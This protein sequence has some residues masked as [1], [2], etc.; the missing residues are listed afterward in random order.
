M[1]KN[2]TC[3]SEGEKEIQEGQRL[4]WICWKSFI[5]AT[6]YRKQVLAVSSV[7]NVWDVCV[8]KLMGIFYQ[9]LYKSGKQFFFRELTFFLLNYF[10][11]AFFNFRTA[12]MWS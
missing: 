9:M 3:F 7:K 11:F 8:K 1:R 4:L 10:R 6:I 12:E 2:W 5:S